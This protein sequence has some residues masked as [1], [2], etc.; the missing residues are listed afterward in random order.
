MNTPTEILQ[1]HGDTHLPDGNIT[2]EQIKK[3]VTNDL[4]AHP[5]EWQKPAL[6][7]SA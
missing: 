3:I 2:F 1:V 7:I 4:D 6:L 5:D